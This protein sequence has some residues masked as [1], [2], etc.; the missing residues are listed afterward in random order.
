[1]QHNPSW[2]AVFRP[3]KTQIWIRRQKWA[4]TLLGYF[5]AHTQIINLGLNKESEGGNNSRVWKGCPGNSKDT[6]L[7]RDTTKSDGSMCLS[8]PAPVRDM[9][10]WIN[11]SSQVTHAHKTDISTEIWTDSMNHKNKV[12]CSTSILNYW[13]FKCSREKKNLLCQFSLNYEANQNLCWE[14]R[15]QGWEH[16]PK[17][18]NTFCFK[19]VI[20]AK[21]GGIQNS[22]GTRE[23]SSDV[24]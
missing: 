14:S 9:T 4:E 17:S 13:L 5:C 8:P 2:K 21:R 6:I 12:L 18:S 20:R 23:T 15:F 1:M 19:D 24:S 11:I 10:T 22:K 3:K 7:Q 16:L